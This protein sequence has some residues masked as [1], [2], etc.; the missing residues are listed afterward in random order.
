M[1]LS[2]AHT[3]RRSVNHTK[4]RTLLLLDRIWLNEGG[5]F[6]GKLVQ[7]DRQAL[8]QLLVLQRRNIREKKAA[9][10]LAVLSEIAGVKA[11]LCGLKGI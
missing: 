4:M 10:P 1:C 2:S 5:R 6:E 3:S 9:S 7:V 11:S 8:N